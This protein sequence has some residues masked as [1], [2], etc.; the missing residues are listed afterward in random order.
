MILVKYNHQNDA[1]RFELIRMLKIF[2]AS[3]KRYNRRTSRKLCT[4]ANNDG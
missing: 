4:A 1:M 2:T 3:S